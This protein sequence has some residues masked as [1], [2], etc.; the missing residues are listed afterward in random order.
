VGGTR[1][2]GALVNEMVGDTLIILLYMIGI[3]VGLLAAAGVMGWQYR[4]AIARSM[5]R[6]ANTTSSAPLQVGARET[7]SSARITLR[8]VDSTQV[9]L[10]STST[11]TALADARH[12]SGHARR[13]YLVAA[14]V[15]ATVAV[16][17]IMAEE[18]LGRVAPVKSC[19]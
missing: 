1:A 15:Y 14:L 4:R 12:T 9:R 5:T 7:F 2:L 10:G 17:N 3:P 16:R 18:E 13:A 19:G 11:E 6:S 8:H